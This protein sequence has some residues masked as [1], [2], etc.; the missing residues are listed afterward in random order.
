MKHAP[1]T[2]M[3]RGGAR[4]LHLGGPKSGVVGKKCDL[5]I[6]SV[7]GLWRKSPEAAGLSLSARVHD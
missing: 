2:D 1:G 6:N 4:F 3:I 5:A 7:V